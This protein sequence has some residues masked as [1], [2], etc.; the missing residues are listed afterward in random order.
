M[1]HRPVHWHE[2]MFLR[3][4]HFQAAAR[5]ADEAAARSARLDQHH[6][7]GW[8]RCNI[9]A[10][11]LGAFRLVVR[12]AE[13]RFRA[14]AV[15]TLPDDAPAI[16]FDLRPAFTGRSTVD[17]FLAVPHW[18]PGQA[19]AGAAGR[20]TVTPAPVEDENT[21]ANPQPVPF[22]SPNVRVLVTGEDQAGFDV[23]PL[24]RLEK[25]DR[26]EATPHLAPGFIPPV[27]AC[28][29]WPGLQA[30]VLQQVYFRLNKKIEVLAGQVTSRGIS[31]DSSTP[32]DARRM[33]QLSRLNEGYSVLTGIAFAP[34]V[35]PFGA[36]LELLRLAGQLSV[37]GRDAR[38]PELPRY[39]HDDLGTVFAR[40]KQ[41]VD[42]L[43]TDVEDVKYHERPFVGAGLR[44]QVTLEPAWLESGWQVYLGVRSN[45]PTEECVKM[46]TRP[47][48]LGM[49][50]GSSDRVDT[51]FTRGQE[52]LRFTPAPRP[53]RDLP[54]APALTYFE[55]SR[56]SATNEW[57]HVQANKTLAIRMQER[58]IVGSIDG[59]R[60]L[61]I[62]AAG[63]TATFT[64][65]LYLI[66]PAR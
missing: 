23:L 30:D 2:G 12:S 65:T 36:Y 22:R 49:K 20:Y 8:R 48:R 41:L 53:P 37:F 33:N 25:A 50:I 29:A 32:G 64:F 19:N 51:I 47:E 34:G 57:G 59:Q 60:E 17:V 27:L 35:H 58:D 28:D 56:D 13:A 16:D 4:H 10:D 21:G 26:P 43:L 24:A 11:A 54:S 14:G 63:Q 31:F 62:R 7:W 61:A 39:D 38:P 18:R 52:G 55:V 9:D 42:G 45:V 6:G 44:M 5:H 46:L 66:P 1:A 3:P 40:L 15:V